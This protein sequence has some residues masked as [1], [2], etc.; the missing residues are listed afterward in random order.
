MNTITDVRFNKN[1]FGPTEIEAEVGG[2]WEKLFSFYA[3][4]ITFSRLDLIG[5][6][7]DGAL[8][9]R[10]RRDVAYLQS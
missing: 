5:L 2:K 3:D 1:T 7:V 9:M 10:H 6:T 4:E 8:A